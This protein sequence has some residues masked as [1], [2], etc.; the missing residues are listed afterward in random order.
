MVEGPGAKRR[1]S[2]VGYAAGPSTMLRMV[3]L[4]CK[5]GEELGS[6]LI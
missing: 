3:P 1:V 6:G 4:P 5:A 2:T